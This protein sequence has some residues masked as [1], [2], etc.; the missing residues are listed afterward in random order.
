[1]KV[2]AERS[3]HHGDRI[4]IGAQLLELQVRADLPEKTSSMPVM[5]P[6][7]AD[8]TA[9]PQPPALFAIP[10]EP[11]ADQVP[12]AALAGAGTAPAAAAL[13]DAVSVAPA[14]S[15]HVTFAGQNISGT[16]DPSQ[17]LLEWADEKNVSLDY[18]CWIGMCGCDAIRVVAGAEHLNDVTEKEIKTLKRRGL[19]PG[20][21]RLACMTRTSG[22]VVVET[23][24]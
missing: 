18:E 10:A 19:E 9:V 17:T 16:I 22:A 20:A 3:I 21:C 14:G 8:T 23:I 4:R 7:A 6:Q 5:A 2:D 15:A 1:V 13:V 11:P 24:E 12:I